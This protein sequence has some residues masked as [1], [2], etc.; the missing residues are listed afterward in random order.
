MESSKENL[1]TWEIPVCDG[2]FGK[3]REKQNCCATKLYMTLNDKLDP[4]DVWYKSANLAR[5]HQEWFRVPKTLI[6][7]YKNI[8]NDII[9]IEDID[10]TFPCIV[11]SSCLE[12]DK[13]GESNAWKYKS[14][15]VYSGKNELRKAI[16]SVIW[17]ARSLNSTPSIIIQ[18]Y[19]EGDYYWVWFSKYLC[20]NN[21]Y[22]PIT[23]YSSKAEAV[24]WWTEKI[25][26]YHYLW[27][28][29][30]SELPPPLPFLKELWEILKKV[31]QIFGSVQDI[32]YVVKNNLIYLLQS[33]DCVD[34]SNWSIRWNWTK[35]Q[36]TPIFPCLL[37]AQ[38]TEDYIN[39]YQ[40]YN[41]YIIINDWNNVTH[42]LYN[43]EDIKN[44]Q[45]NW[46]EK[47]G[48]IDSELK[49][50]SQNLNEKLNNLIK[51]SEELEML[52]NFDDSDNICNLLEEYKQLY[53]QCVDLSNE[54]FL[55]WF[56]I[57][58]YLRSRINNKIEWKQ[59]SKYTSSQIFNILT[60]DEKNNSRSTLL[61]N[62]IQE[63]SNLI[64]E[65]LKNIIKDWKYEEFL[66]HLENEEFLY[67]DRKKIF[68]KYKWLGFNRIWPWLT[69]KIMFD[70][71]KSIL[72]K[73][74][75]V[76]NEEII[77][78]D[79]LFSF[80]EVESK[81]RKLFDLLWYFIY[82][83]D[84]RNWMYSK[85]SYNFYSWLKKICDSK[86]IRIETLYR[87]SF[88]EVKWIIKWN[89]TNNDKES[90]TLWTQIDWK[91][92]IFHGNEAEEYMKENW[93]IINEQYNKNITSLSGEGVSDWIINWYAKIL[94]IE[95][96]EYT[97][98][99]IIIASSIHPTETGVL[100]N[101]G[102]II[103]EE[104]WITSHI[105]ILARELKIPCII[106][107][108]NASK[109]IKNWES[110]LLNANTWIITRNV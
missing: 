88:D 76:G 44:F 10:V 23:E 80:L 95:D 51:F 54:T 59:Y 78:K 38:I 29:K 97:K 85:A 99:D 56:M 55:W 66:K 60:S 62:E 92:E 77:N 12:E 68:S 100:S 2:H 34:Y 33:R 46:I 82:I 41:Q 96:K 102:W 28:D 87:K 49:K 13:K 75:V 105:S 94:N 11:R 50:Y 73:M 110:I 91:E 57:E 37:K 4:H 31:E 93:I 72:T 35:R 9:D 22:L 19:I 17:H 79:D 15:V 6:I 30:D 81:D 42:F 5:L 84:W 103:V 43:K 104:W 70:I 86:K 1:K 106:N 52:T 101:V 67:Y 90:I 71:L 18:E 16:K 74:E 83:K 64:P 47:M 26:R 109:V 45:K 61:K 89:T 3:I 20:D 8:V 53:S 24:T 40:S 65:Y 7:P 69:N 25:N 32:E 21:A 98:D 36:N 14:I 63:F 48:D 58:K 108:K 27:L 39:K 107:V